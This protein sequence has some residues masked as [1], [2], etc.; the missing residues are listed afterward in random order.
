MIQTEAEVRYGN[1]LCSNLIKHLFNESQVSGNIN[2]NIQM[3][4]DE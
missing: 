1:L 4:Y 3:Q 2:E